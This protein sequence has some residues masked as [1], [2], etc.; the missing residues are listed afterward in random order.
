MVKTDGGALVHYKSIRE[1]KPKIG[2]VVI[3]HGWI[4]RTKWFGVINNIHPDSVL[5]I[6]YDGMVR[7]LVMTR[8]KMLIITQEAIRGAMPGTYVVIQENPNAANLWF[9]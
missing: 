3:K 8:G 9:I 1:W 7:N 5:E 4:V 6:L 2:D